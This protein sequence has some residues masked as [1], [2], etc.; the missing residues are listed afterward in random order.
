MKKDQEEKLDIEHIFD[1]EGKSLQE[2][3][4]ELLEEMLKEIGEKDEG[5]HIL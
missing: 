3:V 1:I 4:E 5:S 2:L